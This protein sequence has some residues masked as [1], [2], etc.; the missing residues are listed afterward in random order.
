MFILS[1]KLLLRQFEIKNR[2]ANHVRKILCVSL[3]CYSVSFS[4]MTSNNDYSLYKSIFFF[5]LVLNIRYKLLV[6]NLFALKVISL[7]N[8]NFRCFK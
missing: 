1:Q 5:F 4:N 8:K 3:A 2:N 6:D 7:L